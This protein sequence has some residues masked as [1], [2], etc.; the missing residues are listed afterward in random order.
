[1]A[2]GTPVVVSNTS[3]LPEVVGDAALLV[4]PTDVDSMAVAIWRVLSD[5][6][7]HKQMREKGLRRARRFSWKK[8]ALETLGIYHHLAS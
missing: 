2:C 1:M 6:A 7:L 3:A 5:E 4:D 8:A